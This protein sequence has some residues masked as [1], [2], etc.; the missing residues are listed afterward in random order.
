[1]GDEIYVEPNGAICVS[2]FNDVNT[3][4]VGTQTHRLSDA[5]WETFRA[6]E[7]TEGQTEDTDIFLRA[8]PSPLTEGIPE[9]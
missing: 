9:N 5:E 4:G 1:M 3:G 7:L 8:L 2:L 6:V